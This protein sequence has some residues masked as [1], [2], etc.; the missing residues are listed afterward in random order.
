MRK[1]TQFWIVASVVLL[2]IAVA[3]GVW[4]IV[5]RNA[6]QSPDI[7]LP[8]GVTWGLTLAQVKTQEATQSVSYFETE[9]PE[10]LIYKAT[11]G[12]LPA[13]LGYA[14]DQQKLTHI[15]FTALRKKDSTDAEFT[16][17]CRENFLAL[18]QY[19][20]RTYGP[21]RGTV[22]T[23]RYRELTW[24]GMRHGGTT[25]TVQL[26]LKR[27]L[28]IVEYRLTPQP[29]YLSAEDGL[30]DALQLYQNRS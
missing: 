15:Q 7:A 20:E 2:L 6:E 11:F 25:V 10:Q 9:K 17:E 1:N 24:Y 18:Q 28:W 29:E 19:F 8:R 3:G 27:P 23:M 30:N 5:F 26:D 13:A 21:P 22:Q 14:F 16:A 12:N 4:Y